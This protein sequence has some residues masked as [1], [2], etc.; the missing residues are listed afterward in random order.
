MF[1]AIILMTISRAK[2]PKMISS[3]VCSIWQR[4]VVHVASSEQGWY[5]P[6]VTQLSRMAI[7]LTRSNHV[8]VG[9]A[10][11]ATIKDNNRSLIWGRE[12]RV[13]F[14]EKITTL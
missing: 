9:E 11:R 2:K 7:M 4:A 12:H 14:S 6:S 5:M 10:L 13:N 8:L 3:N 1:M